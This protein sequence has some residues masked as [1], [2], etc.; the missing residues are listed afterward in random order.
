MLL[1]AEA[2]VFSVIVGLF[3]AYTA[4]FLAVTVGGQHLDSSK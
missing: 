3:F 2:A 1:V 4:P